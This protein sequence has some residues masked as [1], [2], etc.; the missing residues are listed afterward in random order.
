MVLVKASLESHGSEILWFIKVIRGSETSI[1]ETSTNGGC[2]Q[3][4]AGNPCIT[5]V[6]ILHHKT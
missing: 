1:N 3:P 5:I 2:Q 4:G 6:W